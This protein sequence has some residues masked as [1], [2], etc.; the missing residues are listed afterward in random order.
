MADVPSLKSL[1]ITIA[2]GLAL[3][4]MMGWSRSSYAAPQFGQ[5]LN[6]GPPSPLP[7][8]QGPREPRLSKKQQQ[9]ILKMN[10]EKMKKQAAALA[11]L[12]KSLQKDIDRSNVNVLPVAVIKKAKKIQKLAKSIQNTAR[13]Y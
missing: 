11:A 3:V 1:L 7:I 9:A 5:G 8:L 10:Y 13:G 6:A 12:A 4:G 2:L